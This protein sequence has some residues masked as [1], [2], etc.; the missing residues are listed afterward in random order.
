M[1]TIEFRKKKHYLDHFKKMVVGQE[2]IF[3]QGVSTS[4]QSKVNMVKKYVDLINRDINY[5]L[6]FDKYNKGELMHNDTWAKTDCIIV[7]RIL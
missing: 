1:E 7:K 3:T 6:S 5:Q 4:F 2:I